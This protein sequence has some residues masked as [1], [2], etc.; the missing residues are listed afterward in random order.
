MSAKIQVKEDMAKYVHVRLD[1]E[2]A[3]RLLDIL[4]EIYGKETN[5][6]KE[7]KRII[8]NF[9]IFYDV[10]R[11][12]FKSYLIIPHD[13]SD[14]IKGEVVID[15]IKL[16]KEDDK[17]RVEIVFDRRF[18]KRLVCESVKRLGYIPEIVS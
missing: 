18:D 13:V 3:L 9:D 11:R 5:D 12:K 2:E 14:M 10:A 7:A 8:K 15:K 4:V 17:K 1:A 16:I 6:I